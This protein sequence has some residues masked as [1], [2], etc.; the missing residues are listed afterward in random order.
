MEFGVGV[1]GSDR[2]HVGKVIDPVFTEEAGL[3]DWQSTSLDAGSRFG[4]CQTKRAVTTKQREK[5]R[6]FFSDE[7]VRNLVES[8]WGPS[9]F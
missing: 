9:A 5:S 6:G 7:D 1:L 8:E 4:F 3:A 2:R